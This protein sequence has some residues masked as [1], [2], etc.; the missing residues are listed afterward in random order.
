[1]PDERLGQGC[2]VSDDMGVW[3]NGEVKIVGRVSEFINVK[4]KKVDP[5]EVEQI[6][7]ELM[8]VDEVLVLALPGP[9]ENQPVIRAVVA[10]RTRSVSEED[11]LNH[12]RGR[13]SRHKVPRSVVI[14]DRIPRTARGKIDR[15]ALMGH[16]PKSE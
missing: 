2:F 13:L 1:V 8:Q 5:R 4:G 3:Q 14:V 10:C 9:G 12:C 7:A 16:P 15:Q 6:I 11:V